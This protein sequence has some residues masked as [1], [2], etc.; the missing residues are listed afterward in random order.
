MDININYRPIVPPSDTSTFAIQSARYATVKLL[1]SRTTRTMFVLVSAMF[2]IG[3]TYRKPRKVLKTVTHPTAITTPVYGT[4]SG[5]LFANHMPT[6]RTFPK[7]MP[8]AFAALANLRRTEPRTNLPHDAN[9]NGLHPVSIRPADD[10]VRSPHGV[11]FGPVT[12]HLFSTGRQCSHGRSAST[13]RCFAHGA[14][15]LSETL[16]NGRCICRISTPVP[17]TSSWSMI[18]FCQNSPTTN[19]MPAPSH[20]HGKQQIY[21]PR[22]LQFVVSPF[23]TY[24]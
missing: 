17:T 19:R 1:K 4:V 11:C 10:C 6:L 15:V 7:R 18:L 12:K 5:R 13:C 22:F 24:L 14:D 8:L 21:H 9:G 23:H 3:M 16:V 2:L 20:I